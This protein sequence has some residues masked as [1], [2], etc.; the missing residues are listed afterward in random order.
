MLP[1]PEPSPAESPVPQGLR[2]TLGWISGIGNLVVAGVTLLAPLRRI[3]ELM[4]L[5]FGVGALLVWLDRRRR[6]ETRGLDGY[7]L[8]LLLLILA[9]ALRFTGFV[10]ARIV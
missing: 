10:G 9:F 6:G 7:T 8:T 1:M 2:T 4:L 5:A 3:E